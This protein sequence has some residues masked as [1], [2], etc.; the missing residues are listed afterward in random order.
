MKLENY[1]SLEEKGEIFKSSG[2]LRIDTVANFC[3]WFDA[4]SKEN[5][6]FR[7][8]KEAKY[9]IYTS[10]QRLY[11]THDLAL[12]GKSVEDLINEVLKQVKQQNDGLL[13]KY[14]RSMNGADYDM[15]YLS[16][17]QHYSGISPLLDFTTSCDKALF[18]MQD[19]SCFEK[20]GEDGIGNYF[21]LYMIGNQPE[22]RKIYNFTDEFIQDMFSF[23]TMKEYAK[24]IVFQSGQLN[25]SQHKKYSFANLNL[26]AQD[27]RFVFYCNGTEPMEN[28]ISCVDIHKSIAPYIKKELEK[29]GITK[30][31]IYPQEEKIARL[32]LQKALEN[33]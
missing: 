1:E 30:E 17:L 14:F 20:N 7:G 25:L 8:V 27:G 16:Y 19:K 9:K 32:A 31:S 24:S 15:L 18:F 10:A 4:F 29:K 22:N 23:K 3:D 11:I 21:S 13:K 5:I 6:L 12:S 2:Y 33:I 28:N 26:V